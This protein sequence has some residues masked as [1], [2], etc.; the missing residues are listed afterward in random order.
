MQ[1]HLPGAMNSFNNYANS[2]SLDLD[3]ESGHNFL[4]N[5]QSRSLLMQKL[6]RANRIIKN[7][8]LVDLFIFFLFY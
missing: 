3:D 1:P 7:F 4:H 2:E 5:S 6:T 8:S